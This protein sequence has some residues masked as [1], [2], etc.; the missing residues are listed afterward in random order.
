MRL[1]AL[2]VAALVLAACDD[3]P[4]PAASGAATAANTAATE[5]A[6][7]A[8]SAAASNAP[9]P[10]P[11]PAA[12]IP[13]PPRPVPMGSSGP[14]QPSAP[15]E[16][17]MQAIAYTFALLTPQGN[18]PL[19]VDSAYIDE[20]LKKF[21]GAVRGIDK[22]TTP[23]NPAR[24]LNGNR[25]I[26]IFMGHGCADYVPSQLVKRVGTT[27][28]AAY[29]AGVLVIACHDDKWECHQSTREPKDVLCHAAPD[30]QGPRGRKR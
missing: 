10:T 26:E 28:Q 23:A 29:D 19:T 13:M 27:L 11:K 1:S 8:P 12:S 6:T 16:Q 14:I 24:G 18:D 3:K 30:L 4:A 7:A 22:G 20:N 25:K 21:E 15:A 5:G 9:P 2:L 17:Q